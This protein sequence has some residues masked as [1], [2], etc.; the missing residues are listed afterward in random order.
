MAKP[1]QAWEGGIHSR[2]QLAVDSTGRCFRRFQDKG[3]YGYQWGRWKF[4]QNMDVNNLPGSI[5]QGSSTCYR[6]DKTYSRWPNWRLP[7]Y[8]QC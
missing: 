6:A 8:A 5:E 3:R 7:N 4:Y 2:I 1:I